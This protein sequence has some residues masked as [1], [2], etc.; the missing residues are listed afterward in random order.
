MTTK[1]VVYMLLAMLV[2]AAVSFAST[3]M[4]KALA[5]KV[6]AIDVPKDNR[7]MHKVP[8]PRMGGL[9]IFLAFLLSV[10]VFADI[11]R[12]MQGILLGSIMIV[13]LGVLDDIMALKALPK[14]F[15]Q[16]AAAGVAVWHG[17]TI[18]FV[19]NPNVFSEATYLNLG[20]LS[21]PVTIIWI[22]AI[23]N[24]VNFIDGLDGLAVGVS[25][26]STASLI[27]VALMVKEVNIAVILCALFGAC[28]GFIPYNMNPAKIFM[29]DTG[30]TFL[31][32]ILATLSITGLFKMYAIIS[33]AVPFLILGIPIFDISFAFLRRIAHGQNPMKADRGHFH[34]RLIDM[35]FSQK[36]AV[37]IAYMLTG[38]LG[39]AA[40][41]LTSSGELKALI[42]I[43]AIFIV[44]AIGFK[45]IFAKNDRSEDE[46]EEKRRRNRM[47][48]LK[49][50][51]VFGTRPEAIK[52]APLVKALAGQRA[53]RKHRLP[54]R[55]APGDARF[56]HGD[57]SPDGAI[58]T[59]ISWRSAQTLVHHHHQDASRHGRA[60]LEPSSPILCWSTAIRPRPLPGRWPPFTIRSTVGH[61]EAGLRTWDKYS[62]F[63]EE[64]N[65]T[66]V[67]DIADLHFS[68]T[69]ANA[70]NLR[71]EAMHGRYLHHRQHGHRRHA[72]HR[73]VRFRLPDGAAERAGFPEP[74]RSSPLPATG[75]RITASPWRHI[76]HAILE[77][78]QTHPDVE[79]VYPVH[80]SPVVRECVFPILGGH[81]RIHLIDPVDV[82]EMH[83]LI[84][85][86]YM[87]MTDSGGL[88][89]EAP[90][91]GKPVLVMRRETERPEAIAAG[92]AS[93]RAW[94]RTRSSGWQASCWTI[95]LR[96]RVWQRPST[97]TATAMQAN[98]SCRRFCGTLA[99]QRKSPPILTPD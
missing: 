31:G 61:V 81:D 86:C 30:S 64:M 17:C 79:V 28:L 98:A 68:P 65:R 62:P 32:Y 88:Q 23:T 93:S 43:A 75:G 14:L 46:P 80:L 60:C 26:I 3:P 1:Q 87:V 36:Q 2:A 15:V 84:A 54:D 96:M 89:E 52:M 73:E 71:R 51:S 90:A 97:P 20:W 4:V 24:A 41:L 33:F 72:V 37:A 63:P 99:A 21:I 94:K 55:P 67:G 27:V 77:I 47:N 45:L 9:A 40:V 13:I 22:V 95:P 38:I 7:R 42:L 34:H 69:R 25:A 12:Q 18:Q 29:G 91:L 82:E 44:S 50:M 58:M 11:D 83:N 57:L 48:K 66:L 49:V 16:I 53:D 39:L 76:M 35:G 8:I 74:P 92:T 6:G 19:S 70:D 85:R 5:C 56:R 10:L 78:V 59:C